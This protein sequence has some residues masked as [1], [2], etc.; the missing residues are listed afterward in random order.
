MA[1]EH[2]NSE[3]TTN[4]K[5][6]QIY[7]S[8]YELVSLD[9]NYFF[10]MYENKI[11]AIIDK[12]G[13]EI[14][15]TDEGINNASWYQLSDG[16]YLIYTNNN[17]RLKIYLFD[18]KEFNIIRSYETSAD[19]KP[20]VYLDDNNSYIVSLVSNVDNN[21]YL[22]SIYVDNVIVLNDTL[23]VG[24]N[25]KDNIYYTYSSDSLIVT[26]DGKVGSIDLNGNSI[27]D[28]KYD[29]LFNTT[30]DNYIAINNK[31]FYG[32]IDKE[33]NILL[34]FKYSV[35]ASYN[36]YYLVVNN[37]NKMA[38]YDKDFNNITGFN[39][40]YNSI[41]EF[42]YKSL[43]NSIN[44]Y[45]FND[46]IV[47]INNNKE[48]LNKTEFDYHNMYIIN[49]G[50]IINNINQIGFGVI[51]NLLYSY[52]NKYNINFY[53]E[54]LVNIGS[55][56]LG[57]IG[58]INNIYYVSNDNICINY[59]DFDNN[60]NVKCYD[61]KFNEIPYQYDGLVNVYDNYNIYINDN[62]LTIKDFNNKELLNISGNKIGVYNNIV[63]VDN[64]LYEIKES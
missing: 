6:N 30:S 15:K 43:N 33:D 47:V 23:L 28:F 38:L 24:D 18:G 2:K 8:D 35:I 49:N 13:V 21:L 20:I 44:L 22:Y 52:D 10:G 1:L 25:I 26:K 62:T 57:E 50:K 14:Y 31:G 48:D 4:V 51:E 56:S 7:T 36:E 5:L 55:V 63:I 32:V 17:N 16:N 9:G 64:D 42:D 58:A 54:Y 40:N 19:V 46:N 59:I 12:E 61:K 29:N 41:I 34:D 3:V 45:E 60:K 53:N 37:K 11:H 27:I 39:M